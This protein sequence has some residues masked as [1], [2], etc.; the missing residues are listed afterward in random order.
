LEMRMI[1][2]QPSAWAG[3]ILSGFWNAEIWEIELRLTHLKK[4]K[5]S[6]NFQTAIQDG[7]TL[8]PA[9]ILIA[10]PAYQP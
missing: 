2:K 4:I 7:G 6:Q 8:L 3:F 9:L 5:S 10:L 1:Y